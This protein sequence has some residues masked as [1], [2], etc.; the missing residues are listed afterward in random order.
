VTVNNMLMGLETEYALGGD[1]RE[2]L[3]MSILTKVKRGQPSLQGMN[4][5]DRY[6]ANGGRLYVDAGMHP[7]YATPE[8]DTPWE[9]VR[10][11]LA[12]D[13][14]LIKALRKVKPL[15]RT[16]RGAGLF[17]CNV[18]YSGL[19]TT[20]GS[21]ESYM[22]KSSP[23]AFPKQLIPHLVSRVIY[24]GAGGFNPLAA[25]IEFTL[26]PRAAHIRHEISESSTAQ[27]GIFHTKNERL[28]SRSYNR[29]HLLCGESLCS[30]LGSW[31]RVGTTAVV[32]AM[33]DA[34][35]SPGRD[36]ELAY[37]VDALRGFVSD[38]DCRLTT[39]RKNRGAVTAVDV[40]RSYLQMAEDNAGHKDMPPWTADV[41]VEWRRMLDRIEHQR[42]T[43]SVTLD[44]AIK[45]AF[46]KEHVD[47]SEISWDDFGAWN[48]LLEEIR[49]ALRETPLKGRSKVE[50]ILGQRSDKS[51]IPETI[52]KLT[53]YVEERGLS[54][55]LLRPVVDLR[56]QLFELD[57]RF[58]QLGGSGLFDRLDAAH[59]LDHRAPGVERIADA[60]Y[61]PPKGGRASLRSRRIRMYADKH[62]VRC[63][64]SGMWDEDGRRH[65]DM[66]D[67]FATRAAWKK[68]RKLDE[69]AMLRSIR[70]LR[71]EAEPGLFDAP[72]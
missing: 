42:E 52:E 68:I 64:W 67:P 66:T 65:L 62:P 12:G 53:P 45:L 43:L 72:P 17:K 56:K 54:W 33:I 63:N 36:V 3:L 18:D 11:Q 22:Y 71:G 9:A 50:I 60:V 24:T 41:C 34:G 15:L 2:E 37:P 14:V 26:S 40:Q 4:E 6:L 51:P 48:F 21:H 70:R 31:L 8:C 20:W 5:Q 23:G 58:G 47:K 49:V 61:L 28:A 69:S 7:E 59:V 10:R 25:G 35:L 13:R 46:F 44:W 16:G 38:P 19:K 30:H 32:I 55:N 57:F 29:M 27:R 1:Q 39:L